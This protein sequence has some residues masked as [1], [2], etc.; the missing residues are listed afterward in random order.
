MLRRYVGMLTLRSD[1]TDQLCRAAEDGIACDSP[2]GNRGLC[3]RHRPVAVKRGLIDRLGLPSKR[4]AQTITLTPAEARQPGQCRVTIDGVV[5]AAPG[6]RRGLCDRHYMTVWQRKDLLFDT[7]AAPRLT[8]EFRP[9]PAPMPGICRL[10]ELGAGCTAA[11]HARGLCRR[12]YEWL[13]TRDLD[14][15]ERLA[16]PDRSLIRYS[17]RTRCRAGRCRAAENGSG[18]GELA[19]RRGLCEHHYNVL[20]KKAELF[21]AIAEPKSAPAVPE[22]LTVNPAPSPGICHIVTDGVPCTGRIEHRGLCMAHYRWLRGKSG[23]THRLADYL[24]PD[25]PVQLALKPMA[26]LAAGMC[27]VIADAEPCQELAFTRGLCR[28]HYRLAQGQERVEELGAPPRDETTRRQPRIPHAYFD[29]NIL[30]DWCDATAFGSTGQ[31]VSC[32]LVERVRT[33]TLLAT[34]SGSA[35]TSAYNHVRHRAAR[36]RDEGGRGL[37]EAAAEQLARH[38]LSRM[39]AGSWRFQVLGPNDLRT[40]LVTASATQSYEDALE[41][42]AYQ[43]AQA[44]NHGPRWF[45]TRDRDFPDGVQPWVVEE[46]LSKS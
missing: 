2:P 17:L 4:R 28:K 46:Y 19:R 32:A 26:Q 35:V 39:L 31:Q 33:G 29:K 9:K 44:T 24:A 16:E 30:F 38:T 11:V 40:V 42:A 41:W 23:R 14:L 37:D 25:A 6:R 13:R 21:E 8:R 18:C 36:P 43:Q 10:I 5:C 12:H 22:V 34:I 45:V 20:H 1:P 7:F 15:F 27:R 3:E